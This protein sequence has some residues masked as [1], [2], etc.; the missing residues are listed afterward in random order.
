MTDNATRIGTGSA[1]QLQNIVRT[2]FEEAPAYYANGFVNGL[3]MGDAY[4]VLQTNDQSV[5]VVNMSLSMAKTM[6][7]NLLVMVKNFEEQTGQKVSTLD[8]IQS[9]MK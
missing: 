9:K 7:N 8:E 5:A 6:A 1:E 3:G 4:L 2:A